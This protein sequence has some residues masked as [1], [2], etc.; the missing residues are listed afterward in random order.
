MDGTLLDSMPIWMDAGARYLKSIGVLP[1]ENLADVLWNMSIPEGV[2][3][4]KEHYQ[5]CQEKEEISQGIIGVVRDFYYEEAPLKAGVLAFL[6]ELK[7]RKIPMVVATSSD[8]SYLMAA[9]Q[10]TGLDSYF[11]KIFT[12]EEVGASKKD[13]LI[14]QVAADYL[15]LLPKEIFVF[16]DVDHAIRSAAGA[17]FQVAGIYDEASSAYA[18]SIQTHSNVYMKDFTETEK[19]WNYVE[20]N[21]EK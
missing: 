14:Y 9:F 4:L 20:K 13:P 21:L 1:E 11:D 5:L 3:Y 15:G 7:V 8:R 19:F 10:R 6:E 18:E 17:H 16:E 2:A 12:C